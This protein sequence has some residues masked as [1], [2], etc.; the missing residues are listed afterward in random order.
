MPSYL[1]FNSKY[2]INVTLINGTSRRWRVEVPPIDCYDFSGANNP[3]RY[4]G[5]VMPAQSSSGPH[6][7]VARRTC[8][9]ISGSIIGNFQTRQ[10]KW[11]TMFVEEG[12]S[13]TR[14][15][16]PSVIACNTFDKS[17][18]TMC[19]S[20]VRQDRDVRIFDLEDGGAIRIITTCSDTSTS[21]RLEQIY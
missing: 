1:D 20:G 3:T 19:I 2:G 10:A 13:G 7:L 12:G 11:T 15:S 8:P 14:F 17:S 9:W 5:A 4:S 16:V 21:I 6:L 18:P